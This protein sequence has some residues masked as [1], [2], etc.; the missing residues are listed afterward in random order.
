MTVMFIFIIATF[1]DY[2]LHDSFD[3]IGTLVSVCVPVVHVDLTDDD[4]HDFLGTIL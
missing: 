1:E 4:L 2:D 3:T